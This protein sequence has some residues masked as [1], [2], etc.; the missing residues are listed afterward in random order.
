MIDCSKIELRPF[1]PRAA[2]YRGK[3]WVRLV[4]PDGVRWHFFWRR[5]ACALAALLLAA[6]LA[7]TGGAWAFVKF[8][9][10]YSGVSYLDLALYP[11]RA[12]HYR[13][14]LGRHFLA[15]G[16]A[17]LEKKNYLTGYRLLLAGLA[18]VPD[19]IA[20][21]RLVADTQV[22]FGRA[23][24]ALT[25]LAEGATRATADLEYLK[26]LFALLLEAH[27]DDRALALAHTLLPATPDAALVHQF[28]ALQAATAHFT[29]GDYDDAENLLHDW[30]L[31]DSLE[32]EILLAKCDWERGFPELALARLE[33]DLARFP[34]RD[35][36]Y[37]SL[38]RLHR[39][40]GHVAEARRV[41]FLGHFNNPTSPGA[42]VDLL[43][44]YFE[45]EDHAAEARE[46]AAYLA[47]FKSDPAALSLLALFSIDVARPALAAQVHDH[48]VAQ[49]FPL[50]AFKLA[51]IQA[52]LATQDYR[53]ASTLADRALG[54]KTAANPNFV[55]AVTGL[56]AVALMGLNDTFGAELMLTAFVN[57]AQL[58]AT[59]ALW[60]AQQLRLLGATASARAVLERASVLDPLSQSALTELI[61]ADIESGNRPMLT[62]N[63]PKFL[64]L[65]KPS[66]AVLQEAL[67]RLDH[68]DDAPLREQIRAALSR[69]TPSPAPI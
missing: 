53:T 56:R 4:T 27:E 47:D 17:E 13:T 14:G 10:G 9:R 8:Q 66:R 15:Q 5:I 37:F 48:A 67:L 61:R 3:L 26:L 25:T 12:E 54:E 39:A 68:T 21:R 29:K 16:S 60:L 31:T 45:A 62:Q 52:A 28:V 58:R 1:D 36:L 30:H 2:S 43:R 51:R 57:Q 22:R 24:L 49:E 33:H 69:V 18:R 32:G 11:L 63:L 59:D 20:A 44:T 64:Q 41:A 35:E 50:D 34:Q 19:D 40:R 42:R 46:V 55:S 6:W 65:R 7:T 23:D 38:V